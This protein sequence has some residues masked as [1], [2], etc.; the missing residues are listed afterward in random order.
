MWK[1]SRPNVL[2]YAKNKKNVL[3]VNRSFMYYDLNDNSRS[4]SILKASPSDSN[5][6]F[7]YHVCVCVHVCEHSYT[8]CNV[9]C[10]V[11]AQS[12]SRFGILTGAS[13]IYTIQNACFWI[14]QKLHLLKQVIYLA[15]IIVINLP[16]IWLNWRNKYTLM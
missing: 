8:V 3:G 7:W 1:T 11:T 15:E 10:I 14:I 6:W 4:L 16:S 12:C 5:A 9:L 2:R 13:N